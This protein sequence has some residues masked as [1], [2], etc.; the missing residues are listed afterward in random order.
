M[1][2]GISLASLAVGVAAL[3]LNKK[4]ITKNANEKEGTN[5]A[6]LTGKEKLKAAKR[7]KKDALAAKKAL[8]NEHVAEI[9]R[10]AAS[11]GYTDVKVSNIRPSENKRT[12]VRANNIKASANK[13][14]DGRIAKENAGGKKWIAVAINND[15]SGEQ[16]AVCKDKA[17]AEKKARYMKASADYAGFAYYPLKDIDRAA[18]DIL[19]GSWRSYYLV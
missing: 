2:L 8:H 16:A 12:E 18:R 14:T 13:K 5:M 11:K 15:G 19:K 1:G 4:P 10:Y 9:A 3:C 7:Q 6:E 17:D